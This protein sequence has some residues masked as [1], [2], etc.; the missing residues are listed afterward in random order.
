MFHVKHQGR[1]MRVAGLLTVRLCPPQA[2]L[3]S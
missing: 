3:L 2:P 1:R